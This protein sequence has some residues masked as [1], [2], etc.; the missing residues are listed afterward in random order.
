MT[1]VSAVR[2]R[3]SIDVGTSCTN[4][5]LDRGDG[6]PVVVELGSGGAAA[7]S[8]VA[9]ADGQVVIGDAADAVVAAHPERGVR[10]LKRRFGDTTP[11]V[12]DGQPYTADALT[13]EVLRSVARTAGVDPGNATVVLTH[14][15]GWHEYKRDLLAAT[16]AR[17]GFADVEVVSEAEAAVRPYAN[18]GRLQRGNTVAVYDLGGTFEVSLVAVTD[19]GLRPAGTPQTLERLGGDVLDQVVFRHV[20]EALGGTLQQLDRNDTAVRAA[21]AALRTE[22]T[23]AKERLSS[24]GETS[25]PVVAPG[26][27]T[28]VRMT[29]DEFETAVRPL[30]TETLMALDR[31]LA[32]AGLQ[33]ADLTAVVLVGGGSQV[34]VVA[35]MVAGHLG[36]PALTDDPRSA[37]V[38]GAVVP[39]VV[40]SGVVVPVLAAAV[41][42]SAPVAAASFPTPTS[43]STASEPRENPMTDQPA[44]ENAAPAAGAS[45]GAPA[46]GAGGRVIPTP[47]PAPGKKVS[48][49]AASVAG[50]PGRC[51]RRHHRR[52]VLRR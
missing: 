29:R 24:D 43:S 23:A 5:A 8:T 50:G 47:P 44:P 12:L 49:R 39:A 45:T 36:R 34:P 27:D 41:L 46:G 21:I 1:D 32:S 52:G 30:V 40:V 35:E 14:P 17:A 4:A 9:L 16:G 37:V 42:A 2:P 20:T 22:C 7:P 11:V 26:L 38:L 15:A 31:A 18:S 13:A 10:E 25:I 51:G 28:R 33:A 48:S 6:N 3:L 19:D